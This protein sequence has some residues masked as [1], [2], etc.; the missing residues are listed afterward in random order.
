M[1][2]NITVT[3]PAGFEVS[4]TAG[5]GYSSSVTL[6]QSGGTVNAMTVYVRL[7]ASDTAGVYSGNV[8]LTSTGATTVNVAIP[9]STVAAPFTPGNL[10]VQQGDNVSLQNTTITMLEIN[11]SA[12]S[13]SAP[14]QS[15]PLPGANANSDPTQ[16]QALR[17][18]A[19]G[20]TT[21]YLASTNDGTLLPVVA[22]N[23]LNNT[24]FTQSSAA[25]ID[26]RAVV[27]LGASGN[28]TFQAYYT[29]NGGVP[30]TGNQARSATSLDNSLWF[31]AD[32]GGIYTTSAASPA[33]TADSTSNMLVVKSFGGQVYGFSAPTSAPTQ[34]VSSVAA[35][36]MGIGT[37]SALNGLSVPNSSSATDF[38]MISSGVNGATY[39]VLYVIE[40]TSA[41]A[42]TI[43]KFSL[44]SGSWVASGSYNTTFG[45]R[46]IVA[47]GS[48][49]G[50]VLYVTGGDG[51]TA[52]TS[53]VK[54]TDTASW[55]SNINITT[56]NNVTL[57]TFTGSGVAKGIAFAPTSTALPD[58]TIAVSAPST[59][60]N[61]FNYTLTV[62][63]SGA[64]NA[65]GATAQFTLPAGLTFVSATDNGGNGFSASNNNGVI[66]FTGG[67]L[68]SGSSDTIT[69]AVSGGVSNTTYTVDSGSSPASGHGFAT[70]NT[71]ASTMTPITESNSAN[72][73]SAV[74]ASSTV[75]SAT[76]NTTGTPVALST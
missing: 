36:G 35:S 8:S 47:A 43:Y 7:E 57:Y 25:D 30:S 27:T 22:A 51:G 50:A 45:G 39:D 63:N 59:T 55:N 62:A 19:K 61:T 41:I 65:T 26:N 46:S 37:L 17:I 56:A 76:I 40:E 49:S 60:G 23:A 6:T 48:G 68:N 58:M 11:S 16:A 71:S 74:A 18:N 70:I 32:K 53:V 10:I 64:A 1:T 42:G 75:A 14:V 4:L 67:A 5:S 52:G 44:V 28:I 38:H 33:T 13:Q 72:N 29:G 66:T 34:V 69:V 54:I 73:S 2:A 9:S 31:A 24:D 15:I 3:A 20:G 12:S 21:G